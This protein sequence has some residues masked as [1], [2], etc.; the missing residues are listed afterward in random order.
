VSSD[1]SCVS[2]R[3][4]PRRSVTHLS[5]GPGRWTWPTPPD[6]RHA[7]LSLGDTYPQSLDTPHVAVACVFDRADQLQASGLAQELLKEDS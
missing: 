4:L 2:H 6:G 3:R 5:P 7:Y 1:P